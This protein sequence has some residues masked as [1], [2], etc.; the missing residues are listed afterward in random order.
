[1][2]IADIKIARGEYELRING[3]TYSLLAPGE[4]N[5]RD[6]YLIGQ[7]GIRL[8]Y[9]Q[10]IVNQDI[11]DDADPQRKAELEAQVAQALSELNR[12]LETCTIPILAKVPADIRGKLTQTDLMSVMTA[13]QSAMLRERGERGGG[14][15]AGDSP[16]VEVGPPQ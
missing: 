7:A 6:H 1:M 3:I 4:L 16:F 11:P 12:H 15:S 2:V 13:Y 14:R 10:P 8:S 5:L 9:L